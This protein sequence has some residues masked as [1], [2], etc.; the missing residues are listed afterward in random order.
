MSDGDIERIMKLAFCSEEEARAAF[1]KTNDIV[2]AIDM[3]LVTPPTRGAPKKVVASEEQ[4]QFTIVRKEMEKIDRACD[5]YLMRSNQPESSFQELP[6]TLSHPPEEMLLRSDCIQKSHLVTL[7]EVEQTQ[8]TACLSLSE[9][10]SDLQLNDRT[11]PYSD[12]QSPQ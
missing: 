9:Y 11:Q 5:V 8:E 6:H 10:S 1:L 4:K 3:I 2:E 7:E 12:L